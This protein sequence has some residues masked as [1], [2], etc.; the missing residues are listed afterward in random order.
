MP[1]DSIEPKHP[2]ND[3]IPLNTPSLKLKILDIVNDCFIISP[4]TP[5]GE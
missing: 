5:G 4:V 3:P 1:L 2:L